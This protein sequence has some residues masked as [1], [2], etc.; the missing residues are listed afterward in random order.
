[1][2]ICTGIPGNFRFPDARIEGRH[3]H[4]GLPRRFRH[5]AAIAGAEFAMALDALWEEHEERGIPMAC[6]LGRF[7][8]DPSA[9]GLTI[10]PGAFHFSLDVRAYDEAVLAA[11]EETV[12]R[13]IA[14]IEQRR[15]VRFHLGPKARAA[16]GLVDPE[17]K[18]GLEAAA[19]TQGIPVLHLGSPASHDAAAFGAAGV[20]MGMIFVRNENGSHNPYE[21]MG[22]DDFLDGTAVL[23]QWVTGMG[24][25]AT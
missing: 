4:V 2:A 1:V 18:A 24:R 9:H 20:P 16:V 3:D 22:I 13:I 19:R 14:G 23:I 25:G 15:G 10:V 21:S 6:T 12:G 17:I 11:L 7:H 5:D 8:T